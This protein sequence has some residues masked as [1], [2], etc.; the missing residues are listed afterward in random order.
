M[1]GVTNHPGV[2]APQSHSKKVVIGS[3]SLFCL[4]TSKL[5]KDIHLFCRQSITTEGPNP[6]CVN[7]IIMLLIHCQ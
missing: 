2:A 4:I 1:C 5:H 3:F 7:K 6:N